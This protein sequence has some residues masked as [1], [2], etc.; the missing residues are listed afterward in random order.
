MQNFSND[1][2]FE[3]VHSFRVSQIIYIND[4]HVQLNIKIQHEVAR[5]LKLCRHFRQPAQTLNQF[6]TFFLKI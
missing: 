3:E 6:L 1:F 4:Q 5:I 2:E